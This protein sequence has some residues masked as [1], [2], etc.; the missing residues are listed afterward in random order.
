M[1]K[2]WF[3]AWVGDFPGMK[4][5]HGAVT[6]WRAVGTCEQHATRV[7]GGLLQVWPQCG[8]P[9]S[10]AVVYCSSD[11]GPRERYSGYPIL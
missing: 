4:I 9:L 8:A 3:S 6:A 5:R 2:H 11:G 10:A 1:E 7:V